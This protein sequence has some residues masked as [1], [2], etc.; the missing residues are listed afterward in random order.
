VATRQQLDRAVAAGI[1]SREQAAALEKLW[2]GEGA[3]VEAAPAALP[4]GRFDAAHVLWYFGALV[5]I[6]AMGAFQTIAWIELGPGALASIAV[7]YGVVFTLA[8][9]WLWHRRGLRVPGGLLVT[10]AVT[11]APLAAYALQDALGWP[12]PPSARYRDIYLYLTG[13]WFLPEIATVV[14]SVVA[15][16]FFRFPFLLMPAAAA[17]WLMAMDAAALIDPLYHLRHQSHVAVAFGLAVMIAAW[18]VDLRARADFAFW[19]HMFGGLSLWMGLHFPLAWWG[20]DW[21][22]P[23]LASSALIPLAL[24]LG[25]RVYLVLGGIGVFLFLGHLAFSVFSFSLLFPFVLSALGVAVIALGVLYQ[26][27]RDRIAAWVERTLPAWLAALRP[28]HVRI[29]AG[30]SLVARYVPKDVKLVDE[31][32]ADRRREAAREDDA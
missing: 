22:A 27:R 7:V 9:A 19:L 12:K 29:G 31:F 6:A 28:P 20:A 17:L 14:A 30:V 10:I 3:P 2:A 4:R 5:V 1:I 23:V 11:M 21:T 13:G 24:F 8:G 25:R 16:R 18:L 26:R 15:L 32:L